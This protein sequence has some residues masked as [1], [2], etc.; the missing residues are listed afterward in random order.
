MQTLALPVQTAVSKF[1]CCQSLNVLTSAAQTLAVH[2]FG[3]V[4]TCSAEVWTLAKF[5][6]LAAKVWTSSVLKMRLK[7]NGTNSYLWAELATSTQRE[8]GLLIPFVIAILGTK[9]LTNL[10]LVCQ[11]SAQLRTIK[12][13]RF[14]K[15]LT[16]FTTCNTFM[17]YRNPKL[18]PS[19]FHCVT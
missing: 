9:F 7:S 5:E 6:R 17:P 15:F 16:P 12:Y 1:D 8:T 14:G 11:N 2:I 3:S 4:G 13:R 19:L 18:N 10:C